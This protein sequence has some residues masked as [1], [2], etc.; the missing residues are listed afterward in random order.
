MYG[1]CIHIIL[2]ECEQTSKLR[3]PLRL[4]SS[5]NKINVN[6]MHNCFTVASQIPEYTVFIEYY[7]K[8]VDS[9]SPTA[10]RLATHFVPNKIISTIDEDEITKPT[11]PSIRAATLLLSRVANPLSAGFE[12]CTDS[13][14]KFLEITEKHGSQDN[15]DISQAIRKKLSELATAN[16]TKTSVCNVLH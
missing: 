4:Y 3:V 9:I 11:T 7:S 10:K 5:S 1:E 13:F 16:D 15:S 14:Y 8:L 2:S 12:N 6:Q